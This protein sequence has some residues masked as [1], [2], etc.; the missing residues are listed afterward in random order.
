MQSLTDVRHKY[1]QA[2]VKRLLKSG[3][4]LPVST[5][6]RVPNGTM[7]WSRKMFANCVALV[8]EVGTTRIRL[9]YM[10]VLTVLYPLPCVVH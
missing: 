5:Y 7:Q 9:K 10:P 6:L 8:L 4:S 2:F 1:P 3:G